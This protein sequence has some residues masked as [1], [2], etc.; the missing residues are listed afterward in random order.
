MGGQLEEDGPKDDR[1]MASTLEKRLLV[2]IAVLVTFLASGT[3]RSPVSDFE[4]AHVALAIREV[5]RLMPW[6][7]LARRLLL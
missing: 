6:W 3:L 5:L 1:S 2:S 7:C 4:I